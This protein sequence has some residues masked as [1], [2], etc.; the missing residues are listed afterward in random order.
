MEG[1]YYMHVYFMLCQISA[2]QHS[3]ANTHGSGVVKKDSYAHHV[4]ARSIA[5]LQPS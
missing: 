2:T 4:P 1:A 3:E 5:L